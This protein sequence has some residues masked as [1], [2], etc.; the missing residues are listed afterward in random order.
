[1]ECG[2]WFIRMKRAQILILTVAHGASHQRLALTLKKALLH[3]QPDLSVDVVDTLGCCSGWFRAYYDSYAIVMK[4]WPALWGWIEGFQHTHLA[5]GPGWLYRL[6][7]RPFFRFLQTSNPDMVISTEVGMCEFAA[8]FK[9][10][11]SSAAFHLVAV[12]TGADVDRAWAQP[13]VDLYVVE[14]AEVA[15]ALEAW[16]IARSKI[17]ACGFPVEADCPQR[18]D[19][20]ALQ[21]TLGL[22]PG[23]PTLLVVFGGAG[24][25]RPGRM[26]AGLKNIL[27]PLQ[28]VWIA[29]R[30][31]ALRKQLEHDLAKQP[32]CQIHGWVENMQEWMMAAD[33]L[34]GKPGGGTVFQAINSGVPI[35]AFDPLP[36]MERRTCT[37]I[38]KWEVGYWVK[39]PEDLSAII[40]RLL[41]NPADLLRLRD[42]VRRMARPRAPQ[43]AAQAILNLLSRRLPDGNDR[44]GPQQ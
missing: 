33:L 40:D 21:E 12:P 44:V 38:E 31:E 5:T 37:L 27:S 17:L 35:L 39:H 23:L 32:N 16:G 19:K 41:Q 28:T 25:G 26:I 14:P 42:N 29:G 10:R 34:L 15:P 24:I 43:E 30:N 6:G 2:G 9:R 11:E 1:V 3:T 4:Y 20:D 36:G 22:T 18:L 13:E 7:A 8:M